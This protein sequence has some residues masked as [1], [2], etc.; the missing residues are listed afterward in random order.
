MTTYCRVRYSDGSTK[1]TVILENPS[2]V[3][4]A[5]IRCVSGIEV[6][7]FGDPVAPAGVDERRR[8]IAT[9]LVT[10]STPLVMNLTYGELEKACS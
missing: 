8:I 7:K 6:N 3:L 9:M 5:G 10:S 2:V 1:K 4:V